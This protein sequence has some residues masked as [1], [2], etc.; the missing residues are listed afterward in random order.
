MA[1]ELCHMFTGYLLTDTRREGTPPHVHY[2]ETPSSRFGE[3]G[4]QWEFY[5]F[6]GLIDMRADHFDESAHFIAVRD[7]SQL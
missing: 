3:A 6:G 4:R 5:A 7:N 1:H 2:V